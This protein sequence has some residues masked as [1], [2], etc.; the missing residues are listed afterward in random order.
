MK[1]REE[2]I[3]VLLREYERYLKTLTTLQLNRSL[4]EVENNKIS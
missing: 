1:N 2:V 3:E 4:D